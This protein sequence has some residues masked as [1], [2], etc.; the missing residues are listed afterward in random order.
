MAK[1][2][3]KQAEVVVTLTLTSLEARAL[4]ALVGSV[5]GSSERSPRKHTDAIWA[6]LGE[7]GVESRAERRLFGDGYIT[8]KDYPGGC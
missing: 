8:F 4:H 7:A 5:T 2:T 3:V 6:A 1:A